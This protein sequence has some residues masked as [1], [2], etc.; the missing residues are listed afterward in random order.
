MD[1][2]CYGTTEESEVISVCKVDTATQY[3]GSKEGIQCENN[4]KADASTQYVDSFR[5]DA[6]TQ[7][8][9]SFKADAS[10]QYL[11][12]FKAD[13][14]T[15]YLDN[16]KADA[17]TQYVGNFKVDSSTQ[18]EVV[19]AHTAIQCSVEAV[20]KL[21]QLLFIRSFRLMN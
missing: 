10:T 13:A 14:S 3:E 9:D 6:S 8:V 12:S 18:C 17:S 5:A 16:F 7:Y 15:Q 19:K 4:F 21:T 20:S 2:T 1:E 11:D